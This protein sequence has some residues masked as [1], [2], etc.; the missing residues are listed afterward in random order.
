MNAIYKSVGSNIEY[1]ITMDAT[2]NT[3]ENRI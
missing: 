1:L 2:T 3:N